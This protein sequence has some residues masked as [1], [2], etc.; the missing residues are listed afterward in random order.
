[1]PPIDTGRRNTR[2]RPQP[3]RYGAAGRGADTTTQP[4]QKRKRTVKAPSS[5][6]VNVRPPDRADERQ[7]RRRTQLARSVP[8]AGDAPQRRAAD[9][10]RAQQYVRRLYEA[11][12]KK[13]LVLVDRAGKPISYRRGTTVPPDIVHKRAIER[14]ARL[15]KAEQ[16]QKIAP[17]LSVLEQTLRPIHGVAAGTRAGI[18]GENIPKAALRGVK[19]EDR[20]LFGDVLRD[21]GVS[22]PAASIGG[23]VLD[24]GL[25]PT[26][27][28]T[29]GTA[30]V[31][32]RAG[33]KAASQAE[34]RAIDA[35]LAAEQAERMG[36]RA[37]KQAE[38]KAG[39][40]RGIDVRFAGKSVPGVTRATAKVG[41]SATRATGRPGR[42]V[43]SGARKVA[44]D[45][46]T[47]VRPEGIDRATYEGVRQ[48]TRTARST[49]SR[50]TYK[51]RQRAMAVNRAIGK[52]NYVRVLDAIESGTINRLPAEFQRP[53]RFLRDQFK[54]IRRVEKRAGIKGP[55]RKNY[56]PHLATDLTKKGKGMGAQSVGA[57][58]ISPSSSRG[59]KDNRTL[60]QIRATD[61]GKYVEDPGV[62][63]AARMSE[64]V[65]SLAKSELNRRLA[66]LGHRVPQGRAPIVNDGESVFHIKGSDIRELDLSKVSDRNELQAYVAGSS[67]TGGQYVTLNSK[68][69]ERALKTVAPNAD[70]STVG[71]VFD[72]A[73][74]TWKF[75]ATQIN[76]GFHLRNIAGDA[77][78][79]YLAQGA[80]RLA[81]NLIH[82]TR[83]L[84]ELGRQEKALRDLSTAARA[85]TSKGVKID[86]KTVP[87]GDLIREAEKVGGIRSGFVA[88]EL[89]DLMEGRAV[90][91]GNRA[92][93]LRRW[94]NN[95]ED[96]IR[97]ATYIGSR[98]RGLDPEAAAART[99]RYHFDYSDLTTLERRVMRRVM[100]FWTFSARNIPLQIR[101]LIS[102]PGKFAQYEKARVEIA[103]AFGYEDDWDKRDL[104]ESEQR[105]APIGIRIGGRPYTI[106]LGPSGLPLSDLNEFPTTKN[107]A[108][109][110]DEWINRAM[111]LVTPAVKTPVELWA[112]M[113]FFF[114]DQIEKEDAPLVPVSSLVVKT[115]PEKYRDDLGFTPDY[116]D[117][118]TGK[119]Q[120]AAP[121]KIVYALGVLP[122]P[123][124]FINRV[125]TPSER[126]GQDPTT[127]T[128]GYVGLRVRPVDAIS[129]KINRLYED[130]AK[131]DKKMRAL[132]QQGINADRSTQEYRDL[133][134]REKDIT[135]HIMALKTKRGDKILP[136]SSGPP[137]PAAAEENE[138]LLRGV[139]GGSSVAVDQDEIDR[140]L[141]GIGY[142]G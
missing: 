114:R 8:R 2:A 11:D 49:A 94:L 57:R 75:A 7:A 134:M 117:K 88:R 95:R 105:G 21:L 40:G 128:V 60:A 33:A 24:V 84:T 26:T 91:P 25:D 29:G 83:A 55:T 43:A 103:R 50:E 71:L 111:S 76:P 22:G 130:R 99:A 142:G 98:K 109:Q 65:S 126:A 78:N 85:G 10:A 35:G 48:A 141:R 18:K 113:S 116:I 138:K 63:Y 44:G 67:R 124:N 34:K 14:S 119:K 46:S 97:L 140:L 39:R 104:S 80:G 81:G 38:R 15:R 1:M 127:K 87:Y 112:N 132:N 47:G 53:A 45:F 125:T 20:S 54:Y 106:S 121:A 123:V 96:V 13:G 70:R 32:K 77:Q 107:P 102:R 52:A 28:I 61:P 62:L 58:R 17:V 139:A 42:A 68:A 12:K 5:R 72:R 89:H 118:R 137:S 79:A 4:K 122:G 74:G 93:A 90:K 136:G 31:A 120:W 64:G 82:S 86:G 30:S 100:P 66:G 115:I 92:A 41:R 6:R 27:Y 51:V 37:R 73:Q 3:K 19:L 16:A 108:K 133:S 56:V 36:E 135:R 110:A 59:R 129:V 101:S 69:V 9:L 23:F 131:V